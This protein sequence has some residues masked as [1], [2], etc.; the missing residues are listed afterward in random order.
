MN[1]TRMARRPYPP[2]LQG[3]DDVRHRHHF[4]G[5][6]LVMR[7]RPARQHRRHGL[8]RAVRPA[9]GTRRRHRRHRA[10]ADVQ[11]DAD[12]PPA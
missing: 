4:G 10:V 1:C 7:R 3:P 9:H 8:P 12:A 5:G 11:T 6:H 2:P